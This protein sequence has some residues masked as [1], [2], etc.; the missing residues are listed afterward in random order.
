MYNSFYAFSSL[1]VGKSTTIGTLLY[2]AL[3]AGSYMVISK[4]YFHAIRQN[5]DYN[6]A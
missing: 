3:Y 6:V 5:N 1:E 2:T 4:I